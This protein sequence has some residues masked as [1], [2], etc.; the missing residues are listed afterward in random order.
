MH[1]A[2]TICLTNTHLALKDQSSKMYHCNNCDHS[3]NVVSGDWRLQYSEDYYTKKHTNWFNNPNYWL[4]E[5]I[6]TNIERFS[7]KEK[8]IKLADI[9]CGKGD[10]L[11]YLKEKKS[12]LKL[13]GMD[14]S[15]NYDSDINFI[16][17]DF[18]KD[19]I[20]MQFDV[21][22]SLAAIEHVDNIT[23]FAK[24]L[25]RLLKPGGLLIV[26]TD[27]TKSI[28]HKIAE[29]LKHVG[30]KT[31]FYSLYEPAHLNHF[32]NHSLKNLLENQ[33]FEII[34]QRNHNYPLKAVDLPTNNLILK[35]FYLFAMWIF[36]S[37][38]R[39]FGILQ[40]IIC[41]KNLL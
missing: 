26:M 12:N 22:S 24:K 33:G 21:V 8:E 41:R 23:L 28:I 20:D 30:W 1:I 14:L 10:L 15:Q 13:Y 35:N 3:F 19:N 5:F 39:K 7:R 29:I 27:N 4:F 9:G 16:K 17:G 37:L 32:S 34:I 18:L 38:P 11:K 25:N 6:H 40:T 31:P 36:F 2:C